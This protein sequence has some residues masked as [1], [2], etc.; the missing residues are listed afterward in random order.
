MKRC[1]IGLGVA[2]I[3]LITVFLPTGPARAQT[4]AVSVNQLAAKPGTYLGP[5]LLLGRVAAVHPGKGLILVDQLECADCAQDSLSDPKA[6]KV[7]VAWSGP[8]PAVGTLVS[9]RGTLAKTDHGY[10]LTGSKVTPK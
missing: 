9:V 7:P 5:I 1:G 6:S 8:E 3:L 2:L 10:L 4:G